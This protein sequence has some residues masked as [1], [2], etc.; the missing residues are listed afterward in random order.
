[1]VRPPPEGTLEREL[2]PNYTIHPMKN[3]HLLDVRVNT[4]HQMPVVFPQ[5]VVSYTDAS[6]FS[7]E[8]EI[9]QERGKHIPGIVNI[10]IHLT[11]GLHCSEKP[12]PPY[13]YSKT[14]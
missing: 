5:T 1:M 7:N 12:K 4:T 3:D 14:P 11:P 9:P 2:R 13:G 8:L 10:S 6:P